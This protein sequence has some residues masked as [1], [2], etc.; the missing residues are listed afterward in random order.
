MKILFVFGTRPEAI[1]LCLLV[2]KL[3]SVANVTVCV[4]GQHRELLDPFLTLFRITPE[5]D[6]K[7]LQPNQ[8]LSDLTT[9]CIQ[10]VSK[11]IEA[12]KPDCVIVQGDTTSSMCAALS[13]FYHRI[14]VAHVEAGLR[15][16]EKY[17]P[18]PEEMNRQL[19]T[20]IA[21]YHF[22][23]T[24]K[25][26]Q[27]LLN[28]GCD[29]RAVFV[30]GNTGIDALLWV[31]KNHPLSTKDF[32]KFD[33]QG[34]KII[35]VTGHRR[36]HF[37]RPFERLCHGI[38]KIADYFHDDIIIYPVHLNPNV[39]TPVQT[40]LSGQNNIKLI[41]PLPYHEFASLM[42]HAALILTDS[43]GIQEEAASL[44]IPILVMR[45]TT[46]REETIQQGFS[47][48]VGTNPEK[49]LEQA[50]RCLLEK[51]FYNPIGL[52]PYGDGKSV[53][54]ISSILHEAINKISHELQ[55]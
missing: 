33:T 31:L 39:Q 45:E 27:A 55:L 52:N 47:F 21:D 26:K 9:R 12:I 40:I 20:R 13:A 15:T 24:E 50:K 54:K 51:D 7:L 30:T 37:G 41:P 49:M 36:E 34:K 3:R 4:T 28:E 35:L 44:R 14:P 43:G 48:L 16:Y 19:I 5:Y 53:E 25:N 1:K 23:P 8:T 42:S 6:L 46:E 11:I 2:L 38:K 29:P 32:L 18:F 22:A 10:S 17:S